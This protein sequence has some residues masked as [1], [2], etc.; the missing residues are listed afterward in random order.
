MVFGEPLF[1]SRDASDEEAE[2]ARKKLE[3]EIHKVQ[4]RAD[5]WFKK[6]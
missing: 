2:L 4:A 6:R 1:V 5:S 3:E